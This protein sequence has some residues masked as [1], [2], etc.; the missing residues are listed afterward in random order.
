M[1][2]AN[3]PCWTS[4]I[5]GPVSQGTLVA[6]EAQVL[7]GPRIISTLNGIFATLKYGLNQCY[8]GLGPSGFNSYCRFHQVLGS[9]G[10]VGGFG[11]EPTSNQTAVTELATVMTAG[12]L[13]PDARSFVKTL[14]SSEPDPAKARVKAQ[15]L[16][17]ASPEF[18]ATGITQTSG[19]NRATRPQIS[20]SA[21][22]YKAL[23]YVFLPGAYD[24]WNTLVPHACSATNAAEQTPLQQYEFERTTMSLS[25]A[26]RTRIIDAT[27][28]PCTQFAVHPAMEF[29]ERNYKAKDLAFFANV[30]QL[31]Q[32][33]TKEDYA[34]RST[35]QLFA[36]NAMQQ[37]AQAV[38]PWDDAPGTGILGRMNDALRAKGHVSQAITV[39]VLLI[40][41]RSRLMRCGMF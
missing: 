24:S 7:T 2:V 39:R 22:P 31:D 19:Q 34:A 32:A 8:G 36:H 12:R 21:A 6:P 40:G 35:T 30:G 9:S 27:G 5:L 16:I 4:F 3:I 26:E 17:A 13:S 37:A 38:D 1:T 29:L 15:L 18:H 23:V 41:C 25:G 33:V 28:Q 20:P 10:G 14:Y 11:F